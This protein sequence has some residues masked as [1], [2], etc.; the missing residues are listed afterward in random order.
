MF[1]DLQ[2]MELPFGFPK[3]KNNNDFIIKR[4]YKTNCKHPLIYDI[5]NYVS[6]FINFNNKKILDFGGSFGN[7]LLSSNGKIKEKNYTCLDVDK[8]GL[9]LGKTLFPNA[10]WIYYNGNNPMYNPKGNADLPTSLEL[11]DIIFSFSV[12]THMDYLD[13]TKTIDNLKKFLKPNGKIYITICTQQ[14]TNS[15]QWY[16]NRR[17]Q[18]FGEQKDYVLNTSYI[19][20]VDNKQTD[21]VPTECKRFQVF[22][23]EN[24][25]KK[26]GKLHNSG[27]Q[28][29]LEINV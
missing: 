26:L 7:L 1:E 21:F 25:I 3:D 6:P 8:D 20:I 9:E 19:Y 2:L 29:I 10:K 12:F 18:D 23:D 22:Y 24:F 15:L 17:I 28:K 27:F 11:Y 4:F 16:Q 13:L 5:Y 14:D